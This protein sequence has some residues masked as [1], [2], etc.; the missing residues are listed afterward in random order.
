M[1]PEDFVGKEQA[2]LPAGW[3]DPLDFLDRTE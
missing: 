2:D 3:H 1:D